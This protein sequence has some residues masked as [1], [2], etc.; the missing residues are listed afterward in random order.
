MSCSGVV[1]AMLCLNAGPA[2]APAIAPAGSITNNN[3]GDGKTFI[4]NNSG[5]GTPIVNNNSGGVIAN[6]G[7]TA[8]NASKRL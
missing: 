3:V 2:P 8:S 7:G 5:S 6:S 1:T 4:N